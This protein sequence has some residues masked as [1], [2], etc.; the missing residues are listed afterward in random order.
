MSLLFFQS[1]VGFGFSVDRPCCIICITPQSC[2]SS[3]RR[4]NHP[5]LSSISPSQAPTARDLVELQLYHLSSYSSINS[6]T[7]QEHAALRVLPFC[8]SMC[9]FYGKQLFMFHFEHIPCHRIH[10]PAKHAAASGG[11]SVVTLIVPGLSK[12]CLT[13][14]VILIVPGLSVCFLTLQRTAVA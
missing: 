9:V 6:T 4:C 14:V 1:I 8:G 11:R 3:G 5:F 7:Q 10:N 13:S 12:R 2:S